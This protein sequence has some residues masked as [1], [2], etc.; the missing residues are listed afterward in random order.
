[1]LSLKGVDL[2]DI[3]SVIQKATDPQDWPLL[4]AVCDQMYEYH[5]Q[6]PRAIANGESVQDI[7]GFCQWMALLHYGAG[8]LPSRL[9]QAVLLAWRD[10]YESDFKGSGRPWCP[11]P[12]LKCMDCELILP[13]TFPELK[14]PVC[15]AERLF[16]ADLSKPLGE[17]WLN[18]TQERRNSIPS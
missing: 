6:P 11:M 2:E 5:L 14:C 1:M 12:H 4:D 16:S 15:H 18:Y 17:G 3:A 9:P 7:H 8:K 13:S 10:G